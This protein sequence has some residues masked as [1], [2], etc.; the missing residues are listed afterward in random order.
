M[1]RWLS[2]LANATARIFPPLVDVERREIRLTPEWLALAA[3]SSIA[4]GQ[5]FVFVWSVGP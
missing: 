1:S 2:Q 4:I 3:A 5:L